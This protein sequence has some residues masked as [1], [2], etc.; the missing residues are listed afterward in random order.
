[1]HGVDCGTTL[2]KLVPS[3]MEPYGRDGTRGEADSTYCLDRQTKLRTQVGVDERES[4]TCFRY[5]I[6]SCRGSEMQLQTPSLGAAD[7]GGGANDRLPHLA[8]APIR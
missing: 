6:E 1:V 3:Q 7:D 8:P 2:P 5:A 4:F